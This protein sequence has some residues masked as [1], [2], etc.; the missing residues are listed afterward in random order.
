MMSFLVALTAGVEFLVSFVLLTSGLGTMWLRYLIAVSIAYAFFLFLLNLWVRRELHELA[1]LDPGPIGTT[2]SS[3]HSTL[4]S[5]EVGNAGE[6]VFGAD[7][8]AVPLAIVIFAAAILLSSLFVIYTAPT[9]MAEVL[10]DTL[11]AAGLYR[12]LKHID[13]RYWLESA[14]RRTIWPFVITTLCLVA[15]GW[16]M[17][18]YVPGADS[19]GDVLRYTPPA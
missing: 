10:L 6:I 14:V 12:R 8:F 2:P 4:D 13:H 18:Q 17:A 15:A 19:I 16:A 7:E 9:L 11:L 5:A 1:N 3:H